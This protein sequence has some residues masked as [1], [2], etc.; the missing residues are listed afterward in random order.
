MP[1]KAKGTLPDGALA[2][3]SGDALVARLTIDGR[4]STTAPTAPSTKRTTTKVRFITL[5]PKLLRG[6][7]HVGLLVVGESV[8]K[9]N[10]RGGPR[11]QVHLLPY[12]FLPLYL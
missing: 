3:A 5:L 10:K 8:Q 7:L 12:Q 4:E 9:K 1:K 6:T 2:A 11:L